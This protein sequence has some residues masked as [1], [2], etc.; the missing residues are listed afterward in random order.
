MG[1]IR[2]TN[3]IVNELEVE[4]DANY[5]F[6]HRRLQRWARQRWPQHHAQ[7]DTRK[8]WGYLLAAGAAQYLTRREEYKNVP[9]GN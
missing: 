2:M 3:D 6:F 4:F 1:G 5:K 9:R 7:L 8:V